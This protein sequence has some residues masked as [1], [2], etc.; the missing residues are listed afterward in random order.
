MVNLFHVTKAVHI[1]SSTVL[2][3]TTGGTVFYK[4]MVDRSR[5]VPAIRLVA[6]NV[7]VAFWLFTT[8]ALAIQI[9][10]GI[11][12]T[13]WVGYPFDHGWVAKL[14]VLYCIA[15]LCWL[16]AAGLQYNMRKLARVAEKSG[17]ALSARYATDSRWWLVLSVAIGASL[18][19]IFWL[20]VHK[21]G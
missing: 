3:G 11:V 6:E 13:K 15:V 10:T 4:W 14:L 7:F 9:T 12:L 5:N 21:P 8:P 2:F 18:L 19:L 17:S 1:V 20:M 16:P